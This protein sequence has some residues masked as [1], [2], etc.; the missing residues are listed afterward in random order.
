MMYLMVLFHIFRDLFRDRD[1][2]GGAKALWTIGLILVPFVVMVIYLIVRGGWQSVSWVRFGRLRPRRNNTSSRSPAA[3][4][5]RIKSARPW[6]CWTVVRLLQQS[7]T[8]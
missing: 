6:R 2:G 1:V 3:P 7:S 8:N 5:R 4:A